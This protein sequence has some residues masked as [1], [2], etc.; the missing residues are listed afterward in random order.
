MNDN[1]FRNKN[2][3]L[4]FSG[5][6]NHDIKNFYHNM[7]STISTRVCVISFVYQKVNFHMSII[8]FCPYLHIELIRE[9][10]LIDHRFKKNQEWI[11]FNID[12]KQNIY[13]NIKYL[14][15]IGRKRPD[16]NSSIF[17]NSDFD[18]FFIYQRNRSLNPGKFN[19]K[20]KIENF[21]TKKE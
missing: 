9:Y 21:K 8:G 19:L 11:L 5:N 12:L 18:D 15:K 16:N 14:P 1:S 6:L 10:S 3:K 7:G 20:N 17:Y 4:K 2:Q 13:I